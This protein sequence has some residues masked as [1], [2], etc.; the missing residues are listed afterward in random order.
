MPKR[1]ANGEGSIFKRKDGLW[2]A[3]YTDNMGKKRTLYGKTQ[4]IAREKMKQALK[5]SDAG[6]LMDKNSITLV[7][8]LKEWLEV[9]QKPVL[10]P[11]SYSNDYFNTY[12][13][14]IPAFPKVLLKDLRSDMLQKYFNEKAISGRMNGKGGL[15]VPVLKNLKKILTN[16]LN[17]AVD[18]NIIPFNVAVKVRLPKMA[19]KEKRI[20]TQ[21]EQRNFEDAVSMSDNPL[22]FMFLLDLYTGLRIG[23]LLGLKLSDIDL[24]NKVIN[25]SRTIYRTKI[26]GKRG[27]KIIIGEP[28]TAKG[29]RT[30]PLPDFIVEL[31]EQYIKDRNATVE[32]MEG[33]WQRKTREEAT[34][35]KDEGFLF[36]SSWGTTPD[37]TGIRMTFKRLLAKA[38]ISE[39]NLTLHSLRHTFTTRCVESGFD[40]K[41]L[42]DILGHTD[43]R[44]TL[45]IYT[46]ALAEQKRNNMDKLSDFFTRE[47][48]EDFKA[49]DCSEDE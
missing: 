14:I 45:N 3:Q 12:N 47:I 15:S 29:R 48:D 40:V 41:S 5:Q 4:Q 35:W 2:A 6:I 25:V 1:R 11:G 28:K 39:E 46:H 32:A 26:P 43:T 37:S 7:D 34:D 27:T 20:L 33:L 24:Q 9:Y 16:A 49:V 21:E 31:L 36:I 30:I 22:A 18:N 42:A 19:C 38:N 44:M 8:W 13:H 17:V 10:R 23:E